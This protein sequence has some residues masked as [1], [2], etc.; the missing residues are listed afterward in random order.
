MRGFG[1]HTQTSWNFAVNKR[2]FTRIDMADVW[3]AMQTISLIMSIWIKPAWIVQKV[4][5]TATN[6]SHC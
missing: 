6:E 5:V 4:I 2:L 3:E 1:V